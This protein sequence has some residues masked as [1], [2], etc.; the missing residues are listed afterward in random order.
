MIGGAEGGL[1]E[2]AIFEDVFAGVPFHETEIEDFFGF[3]G[4]YAAGPCAEAVDE[5][6][7]LSKRGEFENLKAARLAEFPW[8]S[9]AETRSC[10]ERGLTCATPLQ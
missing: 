6:G 9:D 3:E 10:R 8:G 4:A 1:K 5:P 7:E 2:A